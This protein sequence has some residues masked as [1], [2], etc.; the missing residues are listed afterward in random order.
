MLWKHAVYMAWSH[1]FRI[2]AYIHSWPIVYI[3]IDRSFCL[4]TTRLTAG[5]TSGSRLLMNMNY[6]TVK[7]Q[8][9]YFRGYDAG[10]TDSL[11]LALHLISRA[12]SSVQGHF[13]VCFIWTLKFVLKVQKFLTRK[14]VQIFQ[15]FSTA[16][17][18]RDWACWNARTSTSSYLGNWRRRGFSVSVALQ[19]TPRIL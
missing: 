5:N 12:L 19:N 13:S 4:V 6:R 7:W 17:F 2:P 16:M 14:K 11:A 3:P 8:T 10:Q 9:K 15:A 18:A 1:I